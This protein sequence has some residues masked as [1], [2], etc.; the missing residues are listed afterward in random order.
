MLRGEGPMGT[1]FPQ[2]VRHPP[3]QER[4]GNQ[5]RRGCFV[6]TSHAEQQDNCSPA[7]REPP[8]AGHRMSNL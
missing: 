4:D 5:M 6:T 7:L 1:Y 2:E 3:V 8:A